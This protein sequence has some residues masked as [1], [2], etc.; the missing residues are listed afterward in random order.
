MEEKRISKA[1]ARIEAAAKR[2]E[3]AAHRPVAPQADPDLVRKH[4]ALRQEAWAA[5]AEIDQLVEAMEA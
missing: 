3:A 5:L 4:Q 1:L 2:I